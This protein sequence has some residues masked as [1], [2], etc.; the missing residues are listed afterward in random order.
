MSRPKEKVMESKRPVIASISSKGGVGKTF[1]TVNVGAYLANQK[2]K[3]LIVDCDLG[4]ANID[5]M[6]GVN[7][8]FTLKEVVFGDTDIHD[9]AIQTKPGFDF[10][11]A[12]SGSAK[13]N[14]TAYVRRH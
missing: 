3:V 5:V 7:P 13:R 12:S 11:P 8:K 4:L 1:V 2:A 9:A 6:L 14:G 10:V